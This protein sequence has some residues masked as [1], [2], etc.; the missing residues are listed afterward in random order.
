[1]G[2]KYSFYFLK[3]VSGEFVS[4][5]VYTKKKVGGTKENKGFFFLI[6]TIN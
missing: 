2:R 3:L 4:M 6:I 5:D 1:M